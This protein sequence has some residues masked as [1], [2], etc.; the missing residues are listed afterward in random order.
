LIY[1][2]LSAILVFNFFNFRTKAN[3]FAGDVGAISIA[4]ILIF[5]LG[6]LILKTINFS[7]IV[8]LVVY[9]VD[10]ILTI[11]HRLM[12]KENI[13]K[14]HRKHVFQLMANELKIPHV[15]V[16]LLYSL[17][18]LAIVVG[19]I[20]LQTHGYWYLLVISLGLSIGYV[21]FK[22]KYF[23]LHKASTEQ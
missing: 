11:I 20:A 8:L 13:F 18:Q 21:Y 2:L 16:S 9:G 15:L 6:K 3:C 17:L 4:F 19:F 23:Q 7:Y 10:T 1:T 22:R 14:A 5:L 12:L